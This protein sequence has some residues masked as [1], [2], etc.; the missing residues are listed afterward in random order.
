MKISI[1]GA[2]SPYTPELI[3]KLAEV[4]ESL[5]VK[6]ITLMD[7]DSK[8]LDAVYSYCRRYARHLGLSAEIK[9]TDDLDDAV[10]GS[11]F[12][13]TQIRVGGNSGRIKDEK[14]PLSLGLIGQETTGPGGFMKALRTIPAMLDI[15][16]SILCNAPDAWMINYTNP[17]GIISQ[18]LHD[19]TDV[20]CAALCAGGLRP[21]WN[22]ARI[23]GVNADDVRYDMF[24]L[25][26]L[27]YAYNI[28]IQGRPLTQP[29]FEKVAA[30]EDPVLSDLPVKIGALL[31]GYFQYYYRRR[32]ILEKLQ[33]SE[34]TRGEEVLELEKEIYDDFSNPKV[35][36]KPV[37]L[38]KR[39]GGGYSQVAV[40]VMDAIYNNREMWHVIN[41]PN[42]GVFKF[43]PDNAVV[44]TAVTVNA[45][46]IKP[47]AANP[48]PKAVWGLVAMVKNYEMLTSE[49]AVTGDYDTA[50]LAL[51]HHP[52]V[53]DYDAAKELLDKM[54]E[55]NRE[56]LPKFTT[57]C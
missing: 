17:T 43:L 13:N 49:A 18:A 53:G 10:Y 22:V 6:N 48:P 45:D 39:G 28:T 12:I 40:G 32:M 37:S 25:N 19:H 1:I 34:K 55:A 42:K 46:G 9:C 47:I 57:K 15:A 30:G 35:T 56:Y 27:N 31:S 4:Q 11:S 26:H 3:E 20:K 41:V 16:D 14:I 23:L 2:G 51:T 36:G 5:P 33:N 21:A 8:R 44:E 24:G 29:E 54:L 50:L 7:I 38:E 52:L